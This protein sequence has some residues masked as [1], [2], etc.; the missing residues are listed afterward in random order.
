MPI[1]TVQPV[2]ERLEHAE[3]AAKPSEDERLPELVSAIEKKKKQ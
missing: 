3:N 2:R 1:P